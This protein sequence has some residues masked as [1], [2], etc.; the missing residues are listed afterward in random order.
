MN[1]R[2]QPAILDFVNALFH[3][4]LGVGYEPLRPGR[5]QVSRSRPSSFYGAGSAMD[6]ENKESLRAA[7][8]RLDWHRL[9]S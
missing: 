4:D 6:R 7:R 1:F 3:A 8:S 2:S 5:P 9:Q